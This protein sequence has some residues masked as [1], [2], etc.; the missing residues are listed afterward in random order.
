MMPALGVAGNQAP[1]T[2]AAARKANSQASSA[3]SIRKMRL[4]RVDMWML[5]WTG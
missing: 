3:K 5:R 2:I 1:R 4:V